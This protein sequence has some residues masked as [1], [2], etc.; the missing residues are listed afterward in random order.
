LQQQLH[1]FKENLKKAYQ[2]P[3]KSHNKKRNIHNNQSMDIKFD[4]GDLFGI[5]ILAIELFR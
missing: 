4:D 1:K 2:I 5:C 3:N